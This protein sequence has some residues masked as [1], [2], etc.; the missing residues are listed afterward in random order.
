MSVD[1]SLWAFASEM[2][3]LG[4]RYKKKGVR[5]IQEVVARSVAT[6]VQNIQ[7]PYGEHDA[8]VDTGGLMQS[9]RARN[10]P[11]G[12]IL[13]V[14]APHAAFVEY[15]TRPHVPPLL[16]IYTWAVRRLGLD[17]DEAYGVAIAIQTKISEQGTE[18]RWY[19][20]RSMHAVRARL[21]REFRLAFAHGFAK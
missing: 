5:V 17:E 14:D 21:R 8:P 1:I 11:D 12:A 10:I 2:K 3:Y 13:S 19:F 9:V 20:K 18:P 7:S 16:P 6:V 4:N 15:G